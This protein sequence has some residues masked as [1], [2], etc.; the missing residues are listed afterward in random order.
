MS[1]WPF[2][3]TSLVREGSLKG[4]CV[5]H[6][7]SAAVRTEM[8]WR[9]MRGRGYWGRHSWVD[10]AVLLDPNW[11]ISVDVLCSKNV[12]PLRYLTH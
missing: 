4:H 12:L 1:F 6:E 2:R 5:R 11:A 3:G 7:C 8:S 10:V 9:R